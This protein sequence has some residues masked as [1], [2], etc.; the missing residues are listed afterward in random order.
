MR[1]FCWP[2]QMVQYFSQEQCSSVLS[3]IMQMT[4]PGMGASRGKLYLTM[5]TRGKARVFWMRRVAYSVVRGP[6]LSRL[7]FFLAIDC[8]SPP[9]WV[10]L[11]RFGVRASIDFCLSH[12]NGRS[13][14]AH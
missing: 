8:I 6:L 4:G 12:R 9:L 11:T 3:H 10:S 13:Q 2:L 1:T 7:R 14:L 5:A